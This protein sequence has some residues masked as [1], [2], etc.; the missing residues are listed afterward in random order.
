MRKAIALM[1]AVVM[2][3]AVGCSAKSKTPKTPDTPPVTQTPPSTP[4]GTTTPAPPPSPDLTAVSGPGDLSLSDLEAGL[5]RYVNTGTGA[6]EGKLADLYLRWGLK[7]PF[8]S[9]QSADL[10]KDGTAEVITA[11][12]AAGGLTGS[13]AVFVLSRKG[14]GW[15]VERTPEEMPGVVLRAVADVNG[16]GRSEIIWATTEVGA[17]TAHHGFTAASWKPGQFTVLP[18]EMGMMSLLQFEMQGTDIVLTGGLVGSVGAG[19]AQRNYTVRY[20]FKD[21]QFRVVDRQF[22]ASDLGYHRLQDGITAEQYGRVAE[23]V[24]AYRDAM[25][26]SRTAVPA[27]WTDAKYQTRFPDAVRTYARVRLAALLIQQGQTDEARKVMQGATGSFSG[28]ALSMGA[29]TTR[30]AACRAAASYAEQNAGFLETLN[31]VQGYANPVWGP[32]S[33]CGSLPPPQ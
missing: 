13:G 30:D 12:N 32:S 18:G 6:V 3:A 16:D 15:D 28:M 9:V 21:G 8:G 25:E 5:R 17:H 31:S 11:L 1:L 10:D 20:R 19:Q 4:P 14:A 29:A 33:I 2:T 26:A 24:K 23:A 22:E 7:P 27:D